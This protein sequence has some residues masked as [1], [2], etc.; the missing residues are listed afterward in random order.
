MSLQWLPEVRE[1]AK[2]A[3]SSA[4]MTSLALTAGNRSLMQRA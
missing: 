2:P 1:I 4:R 3:R